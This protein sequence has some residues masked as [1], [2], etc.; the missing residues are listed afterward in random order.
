MASIVFFPTI[1]NYDLHAKTFV[2]LTQYNVINM[3]VISE[4]KV[5]SRVPESANLSLDLPISYVC[6][7]LALKL[8][9]ITFTDKFSGSPNNSEIS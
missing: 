9:L 7:N 2:A 4:R 1:N 3:T 6:L 8:D 5:G